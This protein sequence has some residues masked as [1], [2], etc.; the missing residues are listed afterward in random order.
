MV[1]KPL[2]TEFFMLVYPTLDDKKAILSGGPYMLD[3]IGFH[4]CDWWP[5][6]NLETEKVKEVSIWVNLKNLLWEYKDEETLQMIGN[7]L[8]V[9]IKL[10][11]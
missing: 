1:L 3:G 4:V 11:E 2:V 7:S 6:F 10:E 9:F 5:N 8:G